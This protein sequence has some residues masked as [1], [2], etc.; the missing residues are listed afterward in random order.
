MTE[1]EFIC[2]GSNCSVTFQLNKFNLRNNS[3][4]FDWSRINIYQLLNV[5]QNNFNHYHDTIKF[6][7]I[8]KNH[9]IV[10]THNN[11]IDQNSIILTN[12]YNIK[13]AHE[14]YNIT[15]FN[16]FII[17]IQK[18]IDRFKNIN[19]IDKKII[20]VRIELDNINSNWINNIYKLIEL[21]N[22]FTTN[23]ILKLIINSE[24]QFHFPD[25]V[26]IYKFNYFDPDWKMNHI[27]WNIIFSFI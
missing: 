16:Q 21:L 19:H 23:Y 17:N 14:I 8:S 2:L 20:F 26:Q 3:Y 25:F 10:D 12:K 9:N 5:L 13:F 22:N 24:Q 18:R 1:Y 11:I 7:K 6:I 27:N 4:P 15:Q